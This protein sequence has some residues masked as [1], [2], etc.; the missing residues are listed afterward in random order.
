MLA[1]RD[2]PYL[3]DHERTARRVGRV[4]G[5]GGGC[6]WDL[7]G[8]A[9]R[10]RAET[11]SAGTPRIDVQGLGVGWSRRRQPSYGGADRV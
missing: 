9:F 11:G 4:A 10:R 8:G 7:R 1:L 5:V 2:K 6:C 3:T